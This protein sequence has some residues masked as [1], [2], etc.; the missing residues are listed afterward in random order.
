MC[1]GDAMTNPS[2]PT[3]AVWLT[4]RQAY[5]LGLGRLPRSVIADAQD[6]YA[7]WDDEP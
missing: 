7:A 6:L 2:E 1:Y 5:L 4:K 3:G